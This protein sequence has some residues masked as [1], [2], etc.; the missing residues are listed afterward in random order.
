MRKNK[1]KEKKTIISI[2]VTQNEKDRMIANADRLMI[3]LSDYIRL[4]GMT[5]SITITTKFSD[6]N[7]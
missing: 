1:T 7:P 3:T 2:R 4:V 6:E 5:S